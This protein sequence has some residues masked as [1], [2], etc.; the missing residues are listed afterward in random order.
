MEP[1]P[2]VYPVLLV[3]NREMRKVKAEL[4]ESIQSPSGGAQ[5]AYFFIA[6]GVEYEQ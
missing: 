2:E 4:P 1:L 5:S 3:N 6:Q